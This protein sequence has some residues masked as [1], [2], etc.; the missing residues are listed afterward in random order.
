[1]S[2]AEPGN[3]DDSTRRPSPPAEEI[4]DQALRAEVDNAAE[5][6]LPTGAAAAPG[7][8]TPAAADPPLAAAGAPGEL[9]SDQTPPQGQERGA[10][11][12][13]RGLADV[14]GGDAGS[15]ESAATGTA[16]PAA[17][18]SPAP[19]QGGATVPEQPAPTPSAVAAGGALASEAKADQAAEAAAASAQAG[20]EPDT[21]ELDQPRADLVER[22]DAALDGGVLDVHII[23]GV[24]VWARVGI[25]DWHRSFEVCR[26]DLGLT[27]FDFLSAIDWLPSPYGR[28]EDA[29]DDHSADPES[30]GA[31]GGG[32]LEHGTTG[33]STRFQLLAR[34]VS[35]TSHLGLT[36]KADVPDGE[37]R[38][39]T[40]CDVYA[41]AN[42]HERETWEMF[43]IE[44]SG[45]PHLVHLYLPGAFE[46]NP[47]RKDFPLLARE[48]KPWPGLVD[49]EA[50]PGEAEAAAS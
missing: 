6:N 30:G 38:A 13:D 16:V 27:Y 1:M 32:P 48:V 5:T 28:S 21:R 44:F 49:V 47:L 23:P 31:D 34:L 12:R 29:G 42:W 26:A 2:S 35:P 17:P 8:D 9:S 37:L 11:A 19:V 45:H 33:G 20:D 22:L 25:D 14:A 41:G 4:T 15:P 43:G 50:M 39:P 36:L 7:D 46:G 24:D 40:V 3:E 18:V 10:P